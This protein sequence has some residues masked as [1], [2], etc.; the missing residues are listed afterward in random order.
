MDTKQLTKVVASFV[1]G[2]PP[3]IRDKLSE[4]EVLIFDSVEHASSEL[5]E[6]FEDPVAPL[7]ADCKGIFVGEPMEVEEDEEEAEF[8]EGVIALIASG[9]ED[10]EEGVIVLCHEIGHALGLDE[11]G[12]A[13]LGLQVPAEAP[14]PKPTEKPQE[15]GSGP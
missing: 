13:A 11:E 12:V 2:M 1:S 14:T 10:P 3:E 9:I 8:P 4:V 7:P 5:R 6:E 15:G